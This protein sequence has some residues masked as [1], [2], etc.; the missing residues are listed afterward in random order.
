MKV[1]IRRMLV[2]TAVFVLILSLFACDGVN[3]HKMGSDEA[4][5]VVDQ[6][7]I[8]S[9]SSSEESRME[10]K[11]YSLT[12]AYEL[13]LLRL[14]D[15]KNIAY[16][17]EK[18][19]TLDDAD[20]VP[21]PIGE[22]DSGTALALRQA[23]YAYLCNKAKGTA[24]EYELDD[25]AVDAYMGTYGSLVVARFA[26]KNRGSL[27][28]INFD[29]IGDGIEII[30]PSITFPIVVWV[31]EVAPSDVDW[32]YRASGEFVSLSDVY[33]AGGVTREDLL[34]MTY[35][36]AGKQHNKDEVFGEDY[37]PL[38]LDPLTLDEPTRRAIVMDYYLSVSSKPNEWN[39]TPDDIVLLYFGTYG[40]YTAVY[41]YSAANLYHY[42]RV[43]QFT[44]VDDVRVVGGVMLWHAAD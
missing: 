9:V 10:C 37:Q 25:V 12:G 8:T 33:A 11:F 21:T 7:P 23:Y 44:P 39:T 40:D 14:D 29:F 43:K 36:S 26:L 24:V 27:D 42:N 20:F 17:T 6:K 2:F 32:S 41:V 4:E 15:I 35:Y 22:L 3:A 16:H 1:F 28:A 18:F 19:H 5:H 13:G 31:R 34:S 30:S 38:P